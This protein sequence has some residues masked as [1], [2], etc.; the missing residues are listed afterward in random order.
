MKN[1]F[2]F[3]IVSLVAMFQSFSTIAQSEVIEI[4][5]I[6]NQTLLD[7]GF[8]VTEDSEKKIK[9]EKQLDTDLFNLLVVE[10]RDSSAVITL[11]NTDPTKAEVLRLSEILYDKYGKDEDG[12]KVYSFKDLQMYEYG[13]V[14]PRS[15]KLE[16]GSILIGYS[17]EPRVLMD[18]AGLT[19]QYYLN[20]FPHSLEK[21][22]AS[23]NS[24][25][26]EPSEETFRDT[27]WG[28]TIEQVIEKEGQPSERKD[29]LLIYNDELVGGKYK[30]SIYYIFV[31]NE[32]V[33]AKYIFRDEHTNDNEYLTDYL[34][35]VEVLENKYGNPVEHNYAWSNDL[36]KGNRN[37]YGMA[38]AAGHLTVYHI[39]KNNTTQITSML[40]G[41]NYKIVHQTEY[42]SRVLESKEEEKRTSEIQG[43]F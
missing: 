1:I 4:F 9:A 7:K 14:A 42:K 22:R 27:K 10:Y 11:Y 34:S 17:D 15:W 25:P 30:A 43:D 13:I 8:I 39:W 2:T 26:P 28:M 40:D 36:Y 33:R 41:D 37:D 3:L 29:D 18:Y 35:I 16:N 21:I 31:D 12:N 5:G 23:L 38:I 19:F 32:L 6:S 24:S 20:D